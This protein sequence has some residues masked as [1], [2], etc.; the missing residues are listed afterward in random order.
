MAKKMPPSSGE[1]TTKKANS[2]VNKAVAEK[3]RR[4]VQIRLVGTSHIAKQSVNEVKENIAK[5]KP[6]VVAIELDKRRLHALLTKAESK[7][8]F[9][10]IF[11]IG[12]VG[13]LFAK[14]GSWGSKKLGNTVGMDP[15]EEMLTAVREA[16]KNNIKIALIDQPIEITLARFSRRITF[17]EKMRFFKDL[18]KSIF[19][20][21]KVMREMG[22]DIKQMD[23]T[24]V[25]SATLIKGLVKVMKAK[26]PNAYSVLVDE[27][28]KVMAMNLM[29]LAK[30]HDKI[31][32]IVGAG[33]L[34]GM[35]E[36]LARMAGK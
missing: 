34:E 27:R 20:P 8:P 22:V 28:N 15:G 4:N 26:Y 36:D 30:K 18:I 29:R 2:A 25:P 5:F 3:K 21:K 17:K 7:T 33:H 35:K 23:L 13:W 31:L 11:K 10:L 32:A 12:F 6:D 1:K 14:I 16:K 24:K 19:F 9:M